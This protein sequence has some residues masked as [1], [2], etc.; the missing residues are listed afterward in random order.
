MGL[1]EIMTSN[2][3]WVTFSIDCLQEK[4][5]QRKLPDFHII[6]ILI[7]DIFD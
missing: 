2:Q 3:L 1:K 4:V 6:L 5:I 7:N